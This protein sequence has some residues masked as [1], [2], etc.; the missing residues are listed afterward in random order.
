MT[1]IDQSFELNLCMANRTLRK[2][3][4]DETLKEIAS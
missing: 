3:V 2:S 4:I 1:D